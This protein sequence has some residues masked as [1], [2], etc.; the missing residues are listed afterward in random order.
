MATYN[1]ETYLQQQIDSIISCANQTCSLAICASDDNST[2]RTFTILEEYSARYPGMFNLTQNTSG[3]PGYAENFKSALSLA[4]DREVDYYFFSDQDDIWQPDKLTK[5]IA[6]F[7]SISDASNRPILLYSDLL[8]VDSEN[9]LLAKSH[10]RYEGFPHHNEHSHFNFLHQNII[11]GCSMAFNK[12]L[13]ELACPLPENLVIHDWWF[14]LVAKFAGHIVYCNEPLVRYRQHTLNAIGA[15]QQSLLQRFL[16]GK[17]WKQLAMFP[18]HFNGALRQAE[19]LKQ[20]IAQRQKTELSSEDTLILDYFLSLESSS[21]LT[22]FAILNKHM[23]GPNMGL[24][25]SL[26]FLLLPFL[27]GVSKAKRG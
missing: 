12:P 8:L 10:R 20:R 4:N 23:Q 27:S 14:A 11:P 7:G 15:V 18:H 26:V 25:R 1:G 17:I 22:R 9:Q 24:R 13:Y 6:L 2:D 5:M 21:L 16:T 19:Q 3:I